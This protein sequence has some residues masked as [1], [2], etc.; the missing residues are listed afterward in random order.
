M[1]K[2]TKK[3]RE[4][5]DK[6]T[7]ECKKAYDVGFAEKCAEAGVDPEHL[8]SWIEKQAQSSYRSGLRYGGGGGG[9]LPTNPATSYGYSGANMQ[10]PDDIPE[11][12]EAWVEKKK[13]EAKDAD[14]FGISAWDSFGFGDD[15]WASVGG[16]KRGI[17]N[18][19]NAAG[20]ARDWAA[21]V[22]SD[23]GEGL[24]M[25]GNLSKNMFGDIGRMGKNFWLYGNL[26][27]KDDYAASRGAWGP[28]GVLDKVIDPS[29]K[30][31][32][33]GDKKIP[34]EQWRSMS[35]DQKIQAG[36]YGITL[37]Q[38]SKLEYAKKQ[39]EAARQRMADASNFSST[40]GQT[41][42]VLDI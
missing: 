18:V 28:G 42:S 33:T 19:G 25:I 38:N 37:D 41:K 39:E 29:N 5:E 22:A 3:P 20:A 36:Q 17:K 21:G 31:N 2:E 32:P 12:T 30:V 7:S 27:S 23:A 15:S 8:M 16:A 4:A 11:P 13:Q 14:N 40:V 6:H 26:G 1:D 34:Y 24:G 10:E 9:V 35:D